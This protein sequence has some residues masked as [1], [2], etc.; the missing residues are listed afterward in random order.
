MIPIEN[1]EDII[2]HRPP[3]LFV[4]RIVALEGNR[5]VGEKIFPETSDFFRGH[6]PG[7]PITPGVILCETVFQTAA[8]L[9]LKLFPLEKGTTPV[10]ARIENARFK[11]IVK[12]NE[13]LRI[14]VTCGEKMG[15]FFMMEGNVFKEGNVLALNTKFSLALA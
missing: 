11:S 8:A 6:Y 10:L 1:I 13:I 3:F 9:I 5:I 12:P 4:D 14:E 15:K 7:N 2:P